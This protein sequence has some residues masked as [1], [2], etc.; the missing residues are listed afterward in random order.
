M[1][2][3]AYQPSFLIPSSK[4][5][6]TECLEYSYLNISIIFN[7]TPTVELLLGF[8]G[9]GFLTAAVCGDLFTSPPPAYVSAAL[10]AVSDKSKVSFVV[11]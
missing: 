7:G 11:L 6:K 5:Q 1:L 2:L 4:K 9:R 8:V 10:E 3:R